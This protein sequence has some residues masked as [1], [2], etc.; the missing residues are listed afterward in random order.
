MRQKT[1]FTEIVLQWI[2]ESQGRIKPST[3]MKYEQLIRNYINPFFQ[4]YPCEEL[5]EA[6]LQK[7]YKSLNLQLSSGN[8]RTI[9][10][11][12]NNTL[13]YACLNQILVKKLYIKPC[14]SKAKPMVRIFSTE[15]QIRI[16]NYIFNHHSYSSLA[17]FLA[18]YTGMRIGELCALRWSDLDFKK[19]SVE[20]TKTVQRLKTESFES[21][22]K[23]ELI[24]SVPKSSAS[25]RIIPLP[26]FAGKYIL[27]T[28]SD[29]D[30]GGFLLAEHRDVPLDPRTLQYAYQKMLKRIG[31]PYL[32]FH[33]LRH[34]FATRCVTMGWDM[35]TLSEVL[36]HS[37]IKVT[38]EYYFHS[39]FEYKKAQ[40]NKFTPLSE[41]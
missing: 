8:I 34:T 41:N 2:D 9:L 26:D 23:T 3:K 28:Y 21:T 1:T 39:S 32:N 15:E 14:L 31:V 30:Q 5:D 10:M 35:K 4:E 36:G 18:L 19:G 7:F 6:V 11:I 38:M 12:V 27:T 13:E 20:V 25:Y 37:D 22:N 33:C 29:T 16:E 17:V 24:L 40:M